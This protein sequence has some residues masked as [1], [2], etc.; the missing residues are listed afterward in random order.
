MIDEIEKL[1]DQATDN[2]Q[3]N[4]TSWDVVGKAIDYLYEIASDM[5]ESDDSN[6]VND[7]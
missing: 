7:K 1:R 4:E 6:V 2:H 3:M 5:D